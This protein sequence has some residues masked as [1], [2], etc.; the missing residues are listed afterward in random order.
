MS[1]FAEYTT[2]GKTQ[3]VYF[4]Y[5][6][7]LHLA[8]MESRCPESRY[9]GLGI[10][11]DYKWQI[12]TRGFANVIPS[13]GDRVEGLCYLLSKKDERILDR[14]EGVPTAYEKLYLP[15]DVFTPNA[16]I[17][18]RRVREVNER[19]QW[20]IQ[21][22]RDAHLREQAIHHDRDRNEHFKITPEYHANTSVTLTALVYV[23]QEEVRDGI[24][25]EEYKTRIA[26]G[27]RDAIALG[28]P[29]KYFDRNFREPMAR[30][31]RDTRTH[32]TRRSE[33]RHPGR[34]TA[35]PYLSRSADHE[36]SY[37]IQGSIP[38]AYPNSWQASSDGPPLSRSVDHEMA[39][40][41]PG[42]IPTSYPAS[43]QASSEGPQEVS[44]NTNG[45]AADA[46]ADALHHSPG[47]D[48]EV[49]RPIESGEVI[50]AGEALVKVEAVKR[51]TRT[52]GGDTPAQ[53][54]VMAL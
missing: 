34:P 49:V 16:F 23:N 42:L 14:S 6:S 38:T 39:D 24:P 53:E 9:Q 51:E 44:K 27:V 52:E 19:I 4:A 43:G 8:Q 41:M 3:T 15:V 50:A 29:H 18:G 25:R 32:V 22:L 2:T 28:I 45:K 35:S 33:D 36:T 37:E 1:R 12:N 10:L 48:R 20:E 46:G 21:Q 26:A 40:A 17:S 13:P 11:Y 5:G 7:N 54:T 31:N 47:Q 30:T